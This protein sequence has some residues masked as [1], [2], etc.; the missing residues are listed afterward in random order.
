MQVVFIWL[1]RART[2]NTIPM[3]HCS[4]NRHIVLRP[5]TRMLQYTGKQD[6]GTCTVGEWLWPQLKRL[7]EHPFSEIRQRLDL[8]YYVAHLLLLLLQCNSSGLL[9]KQLPLTDFHG[10]VKLIEVFICV[11]Q[12]CDRAIVLPHRPAPVFIVV[13]FFRIW[14]LYTVSGMKLLN[15]RTHTYVHVII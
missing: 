11:Q 9:M 7:Q 8:I 4:L 13:T 14:T 5:Q 15:A 1:V 12:F 10:I 6:T 2:T 3:T